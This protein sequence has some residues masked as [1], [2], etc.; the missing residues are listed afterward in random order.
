MLRGDFG[1][2]PSAFPTSVMT[3]IGRALPWTAGLLTL[4]TLISWVVGN[5]LGAL[6]AIS[7]IAA[8]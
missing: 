1:P 4:A 6:P 7:A 5:L 3:S 2:S 8:P